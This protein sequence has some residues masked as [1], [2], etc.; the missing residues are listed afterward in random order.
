VAVANNPPPLPQVLVTRA[1][2]VEIDSGI[3]THKEPQAEA[4]NHYC[5]QVRELN[6]YKTERTTKTVFS[7]EW[8]KKYFS[9]FLF[10]TF[11]H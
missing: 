6:V 11:F 5:Y 1:T 8:F 9:F 3:A 7:K 4:H 2:V 10:V